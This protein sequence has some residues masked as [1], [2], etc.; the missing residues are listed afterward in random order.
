[1][2]TKGCG[3]SGSPWIITADPGQAIQLNIIDFGLDTQTSNLVSCRSVYGYIRERALGINHSICGGRNRE[4]ALYT[5]KTNT[6]EIEILPK[7]DR[8]KAQFL[9]Q[10]DGKKACIA[11]HYIY[12][13][14]APIIMSTVVKEILVFQ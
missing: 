2:D 5:S 7:R 6:I 4:G 13:L 14:L 8:N 12:L 3:S 9:I 11:S 1:M 10:Y